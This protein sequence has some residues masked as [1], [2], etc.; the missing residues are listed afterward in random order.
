MK[1]K[2]KYKFCIR[3][4]I[5][6]P[7]KF[8]VQYNKTISISSSCCGPPAY[9]FYW[10]NAIV[11]VFVCVCVCVFVYACV[12]VSLL[13]VCVCACVCV[14]VCLCVVYEHIHRC[15]QILIVQAGQS[16]QPSLKN[17]GSRDS[18]LAVVGTEVSRA[19][20]SIIMC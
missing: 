20:V 11:C 8:H 17:S 2:T 5:F 18:N 9:F 19:A 6:L 3:G 12:Y 10:N 4:K 13:C 16:F 1:R 14:S 7:R 15:T